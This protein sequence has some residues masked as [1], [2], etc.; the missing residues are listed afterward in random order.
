MIKLKNIK[1]AIS[2]PRLSG[3]VEQSDTSDSK[4]VERYKWNILLSESLYTSLHIFEIS[5]RNRI[6]NLATIHW[7]NDWLLNGN[8]SFSTFHSQK[9]DKA[10]LDLQKSRKII[11]TPR[12]IA[13]LNL[14]FW[15]S[16]FDHQYFHD[17]TS[18][19]IIDVFPNLDKKEIKRN[20]KIRTRLRNTRML[21]NRVFH[22]EPVWNLTPS[23]EKKYDELIEAISWINVDMAGWLN[24]FCRF[25][26]IWKNHPQYIAVD[27]NRDSDSGS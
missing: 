10:K 4:S 20:S 13:E 1:Q 16:L 15:T 19:I 9:I 18:K 23:I 2:A 6:H 8:V 3:F 27:N 11:E 17:F 14:G 24:S 7:G 22:Y 25:K 26:E 21:R 12:I 5:F